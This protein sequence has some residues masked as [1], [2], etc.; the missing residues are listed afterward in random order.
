MLNDSFSITD[1]FL[2]PTTRELGEILGPIIAFNADF[3]AGS[4]IR[5]RVQYEADEEEPSFH[6]V[7][8]FP[9]NFNY[10]TTFQQNNVHHNDVQQYGLQQNNSQYNDFHDDFQHDFPQ[11]NVLQHNNHP[12]SAASNSRLQDMGT[13]NHFDWDGYRRKLLEGQGTQSQDVFIQDDT[14]YASRR[15]SVGQNGPPSYGW[16]FYRLRGINPRDDLASFNAFIGEK[17]PQP[18]PHNP[19][20]TRRS[21]ADDILYGLTAPLGNGYPS[22]PYTVGAGDE[23]NQGK[24]E[25]F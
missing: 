4:H 15:L 8:S 16:Q 1:R 25:F 17:Y 12:L 22:T 21:I 11:H 2:V 23:M 3:N 14:D 24:P 6:T 10:S 13:G 9:N 18:H 5:S 7:P 20:F 19:V